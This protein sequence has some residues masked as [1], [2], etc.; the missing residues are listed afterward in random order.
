[1]LGGFNAME[2]LDERKGLNQD[3]NGTRDTTRKM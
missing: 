3:S 2:K 1:M